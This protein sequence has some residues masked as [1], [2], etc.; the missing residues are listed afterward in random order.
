MGKMGG[1]GRA[2]AEKD[3]RARWGK[4][5]HRA[6]NCLLHQAKAPAHNTL[7]L[8]TDFPPFSLGLI[9]RD[10][11]VWR[12]WEVGKRKGKRYDKYGKF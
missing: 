4:G 9:Y 3:C 11:L 5:L 8:G 6:H 1:R 10:G 12:G 2:S 7:F